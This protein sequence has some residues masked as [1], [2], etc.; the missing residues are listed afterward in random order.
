CPPVP[1]ELR[2]DHPAP[3]RPGTAVDELATRLA[4]LGH[5]PLVVPLDHDPAVHAVLPFV[6]QVVC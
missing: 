1:P 2:G 3:A 4:R 6:V 5:R